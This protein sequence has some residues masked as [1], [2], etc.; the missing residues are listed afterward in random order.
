MALV[1]ILSGNIISGAARLGDVVTV[2]D[3]VVDAWVR[4]G[5]VEVASGVE[6][7]VATPTR[8]GRKKRGEDDGD[9][10]TE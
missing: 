3:S 1:K 8:R 5:L 2:P 7:E 4:A 9:G 10:N 6:F